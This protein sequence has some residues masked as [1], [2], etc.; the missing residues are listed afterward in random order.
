M[1]IRTDFVTNSSSSSFIIGR[2]EELTQKQKNAIVEYV[3]ENMLGD[4]EITMEN[5]EEFCSDYC[6]YDCDREKIELEL[7]KGHKVYCG[8]VSFRGD[9]ETA[10]IYESLW[11]AIKRADPDSFNE[12]DT[13][14]GY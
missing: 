12:I 11:D 4:K 3:L 9:W 5:I 7:A 1:K 13:D 6:I 8:T 14:L 10:D 2:K